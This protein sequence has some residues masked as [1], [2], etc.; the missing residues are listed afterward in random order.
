MRNIVELLNEPFEDSELNVVNDGKHTSVSVDSLALIRRLNNVVGPAWK[1]TDGPV[2]IA[3]T[4]CAI[5]LSLKIEGVGERSMIGAMPVDA[6]RVDIALKGA[7]TNSFVRCCGAF[8]MLPTPE[9][10][11]RLQGGSN[12]KG[13]ALSEKARKEMDDRLNAIVDKKQGAWE[14]DDAG[15]VDQK[16]AAQ[17]NAAEEQEDQEEQHVEESTEQESEGPK[18]DPVPTPLE[19]EVLALDAIREAVGSSVVDA[20]AMEWNLDFVLHV[21][22][23]EV[24]GGDIRMAMRAMRFP[25]WDEKT[26]SIKRFTKKQGLALYNEYMGK[27]DRWADEQ[28]AQAMQEQKIDEV[29]QKPESVDPGE[30]LRKQAEEPKQEKEFTGDLPDDV[31]DRRES[32]PDGLEEAFMIAEK[33]EEKGFTDANYEERVSK[34]VLE[35]WPDL[36]TFCFFAPKEVVDML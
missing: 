29:A 11:T 13:P 4:Y 9:Q 26:E 30:D 28:I 16:Q 7:E 34:T 14:D 2:E 21:F 19:D 25:G 15:V 12:T 36:D 3:G 33:M 20:A 27:T 35:R 24:A 8:G 23:G 6:G 5:R 22:G 18:T 31:P 1:T 10:I 32:K 17:E